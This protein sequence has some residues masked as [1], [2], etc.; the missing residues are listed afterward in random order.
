M[1]EHMQ[2]LGSERV[3]KMSVCSTSP[4]TPPQLAKAVGCRLQLSKPHLLPEAM[5]Q[6]AWPVPGQI[7]TWFSQGR[8]FNG[9]F[10]FFGAFVAMNDGGEMWA[11]KGASIKA[12]RIR[13]S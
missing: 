9:T 3:I 4:A 5:N 2:T 11:L 7:L 12:P 10:P 6:L 8:F 13:P 1:G